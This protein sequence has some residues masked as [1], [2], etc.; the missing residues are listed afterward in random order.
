MK[1]VNA[2]RVASAALLL[3]SANERKP[4]KKGKWVAAKLNNTV[5][6]N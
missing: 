5:E 1:V 2:N 3:L 6:T 4:K